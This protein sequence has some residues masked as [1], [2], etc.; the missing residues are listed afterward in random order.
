[1]S[2]VVR[3]VI[4]QLNMLWTLMQIIVQWWLWHNLWVA[5][6]HAELVE[7]NRVCFFFRVCIWL[8]PNTADRSLP[9][10]S[11]SILGHGSSCCSQQATVRGGRGSQAC[12]W[13]LSFSEL[14]PG[15]GSAYHVTAVQLV[16]ML[17]TQW[18]NWAPEKKTPWNE[19]TQVNFPWTQ[20]GLYMQNKVPLTLRLMH[21]LCW[22][23]A[24][25]VIS[26]QSI[27]VCMC[28]PPSGC[29]QWENADEHYW[30]NI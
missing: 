1:M 14:K 11:G 26:H 27:C 28:N 18:C 24:K 17:L 30:H 21:H 6:C 9:L 4:Y 23:P 29:S 15:H 12:E 3:L 20:R 8:P 10:P 25:A 16:G 13:M 19:T 7:N 5:L 2:P 22:S